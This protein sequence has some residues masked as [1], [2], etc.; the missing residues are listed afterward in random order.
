MGSE[1]ELECGEEKYVYNILWH[2]VFGEEMVTS[3]FTYPHFH[4]EKKQTS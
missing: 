2:K 1:G 4:D 3:R